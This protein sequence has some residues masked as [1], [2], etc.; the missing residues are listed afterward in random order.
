MNVEQIH[1]TQRSL[2]NHH[3][4]HS[5]NLIIYINQNK[6]KKTLAKRNLNMIN[7]NNII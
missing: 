5:C 7:K 4:S 2:T 3:Y 1:L 6:Y